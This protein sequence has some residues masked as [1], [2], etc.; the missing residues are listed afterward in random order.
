MFCIFLQ[1]P[2]SEDLGFDASDRHHRYH[3]SSSLKF[4]Q[5]T[6]IL[7]HT[8]CHPLLPETIFH[9]LD[10]H[11][12]GNNSH[13]HGQVMLLNKISVLLQC[14]DDEFGEPNDGAAKDVAKI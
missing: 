8:C 14:L 6:P 3:P 10:A 1:V 2:H 13:Q 12:D 4:H 5:L 9:H 7:H 11:K